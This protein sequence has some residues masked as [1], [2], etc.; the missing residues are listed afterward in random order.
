MMLKRFFYKRLYKNFYELN[1]DISPQLPI[2]EACF[3]VFD[4]ETTGLDLR[5]D[6]PI[7][8]GALK[9]KA[10][11][12]DLS[13]AYYT[14]IKTVKEP[15]QSLKVHGI[16]PT[17]LEKAKEPTEVCKEFISY[18]KNCLFVGYFLHIDMAMIKKLVKRECGGFFAPYGVDILDMIENK[19][20]LPTLEELLT[21]LRLPK[22]N[23]HHPLE[24]AYMTALA[25]LKLL[26]AKNYRRLKDLPYRVY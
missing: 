2:E 13:D 25:F 8:V 18:S 4:T 10:L 15:G 21:Q 9:I 22:S 11:R 16:M 1:W 6:E 17:D 5:K 12:I 23:F 24:D 3:V 14:L 7:A 19:D 20:S 26:K